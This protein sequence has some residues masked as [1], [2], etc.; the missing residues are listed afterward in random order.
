MWGIEMKKYSLPLISVVAVFFL[1]GC[2][3]FNGSGDQ[4]RE[5]GND[6]PVPALS[7]T[8]KFQNSMTLP[9][10]IEEFSKMRVARKE[11]FTSKIPVVACDWP[12]SQVPNTH[13]MSGSLLS[14][15]M[16]SDLIDEN[17]LKPDFDSTTVGESFSSTE[18]I[19]DPDHFALS[20][21]S[22]WKAKDPT[23]SAYKMDT[24]GSKVYQFGGNDGVLFAKVYQKAVVSYD[25]NGDFSS[26]SNTN[27]FS[28]VMEYNRKS[29]RVLV[30]S[31]LKMK[32]SDT[33]V[34]TIQNS[35]IDLAK[36]TIVFH[37]EVSSKAYGTTNI[38]NSSYQ[39][40]DGKVSVSWNSEYGAE[41]IQVPGIDPVSGDQVFDLKNS[42]AIFELCLDAGDFKEKSKSDAL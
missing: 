32:T 31:V 19:V 34:L 17:D 29:N 42:E 3:D 9:E 41:T 38:L 37:S 6:H 5:N 21:I 28:A 8:E 2:G 36:E 40:E 13:K 14:S 33:D 11:F 16:W 10:L 30:K 15:S 35:T 26:L 24:E 27:E 7:F 12:E 18:E 4:K 23:D 22:K 20:Y 39:H 1:V 25:P